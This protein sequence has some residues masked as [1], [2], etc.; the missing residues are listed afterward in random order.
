MKK[1]KINT[2]ILVIITIFF[3]SYV[4]VFALSQIQLK[5]N[6]INYINSKNINNNYSSNAK[7]FY[8]QNFK[9][10]NQNYSNDYN[11]NRWKLWFDNET[12]SNKWKTEG[13]NNINYYHF[14]ND[15][16]KQYVATFTN[17]YRGYYRTRYDYNIWLNFIKDEIKNGIFW[18]DGWLLISSKL[19]GSGYKN[20][21][22]LYWNNFQSKIS[23]FNTYQNYTKWRN[24]FYFQMNHNYWK[25]KGINLIKSFRFSKSKEI[26]SINSYVKNPYNYLG[27]LY[28]FSFSRNY[29]SRQIRTFKN[30]GL[31]LIYHYGLSTNDKRYYQ[32]KFL[33]RNNYNYKNNYNYTRWLNIFK[34]KVKNSY[35][36]KG[37]RKINSKLWTQSKKRYY[38]ANFLRSNGYNYKNGYNYNKWMSWIN[39][40]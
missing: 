26:S 2:L 3:S 40:K 20:A 30:N 34:S 25:N 13:L 7:N 11:Y 18:S 27:V 29:T 21:R 16:K 14:Q 10:K 32:N 36:N 28:Y 4:N 22:K 12:N 15:I 38:I 31:Y 5:Q 23:N 33:Q 8:I 24:W 9:N 19:P 17:T 35:K 37:L 1:F 39:K 6:G